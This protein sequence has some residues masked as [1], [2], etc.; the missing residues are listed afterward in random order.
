MTSNRTSL[1]LLAAALSCPVAGVQ[2]AGQGALANNPNATQ[3]VISVSGPI[4]GVGYLYVCATLPPGFGGQP[5]AGNLEA[6]RHQGDEGLHNARDPYV[7]TS[8]DCS[9]VFFDIPLDP[10]PGNR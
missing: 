3:S 4:P 1:L 5:N 2:A 9:T 6:L 8:P 7:S 10:G